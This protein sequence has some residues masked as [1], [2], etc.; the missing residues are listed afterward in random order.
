MELVLR[1][2][3]VYNLLGAP[4]NVATANQI[5]VIIQQLPPT[6][7]SAIK[8]AALTNPALN[9]KYDELKKYV[10]LVDEQLK[11]ELASRQKKYV[12]NRYNRSDA[13]RHQHQGTQSKS[14]GA[15]QQHNNSISHSNNNFKKTGGK[16]PAKPFA[17]SC[18][19]CG[20]K[21]HR[22]RDCRKAS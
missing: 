13:N 11:T 20:A 19:H 15:Q 22:I 18:D 7:S 10:S 5:A 12:P 14:A 9:T 6:T 21:G 17:G 8:I 3:R 16:I 4:H 2:E 1:A